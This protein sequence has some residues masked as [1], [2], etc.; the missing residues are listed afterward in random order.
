MAV[1]PVTLYIVACDGHGCD[2]VTEP[3]ISRAGARL[4]FRRDYDGVT[5]LAGEWPHPARAERVTLPERHYCGECWATRYRAETG[6]DRE[7][8]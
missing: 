7:D 4:A 3:Y 2:V 8:S 6:A 1:S 5:L